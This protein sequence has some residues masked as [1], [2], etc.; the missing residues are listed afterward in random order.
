MWSQDLL[1][2][3]TL[4]YKIE[5]TDNVDDKSAYKNGDKAILRTEVDAMYLTEAK[6]KDGVTYIF[7][8]GNVGDAM[9]TLTADNGKTY[10]YKITAFN[11][12]NT[13]NI[14]LIDNETKKE[15][16]AL[17]DYKDSQNI[18]LTFND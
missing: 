14:T 12:N 1:N 8:G 15:Y 5:F 2:G 11:T 13:A 16:S 9:G 17:L 7:D 6:D 18:T 4:Y 3:S 10:S